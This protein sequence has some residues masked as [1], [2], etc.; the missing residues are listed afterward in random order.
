MCLMRITDFRCD[1]AGGAEFVLHG[2][3]TSFA[4]ALRV[5]MSSNVP[6]PAVERV[7]IEENTS[8]FAD[9]FI[10]HRVGLIPIR[11]PAAGE[12]AV[13]AIGPGRVYASQISSDAYT[14]MRGDVIL[15]SLNSGETLRMKMHVKTDTGARHARHN[16][17]VAARFAPRHNGVLH[18]ECLCPHTERGDVCKECGLRACTEEQASREMVHFFQFETTG[19]YEPR[20]LLG[21]ALGSIRA[22]LKKISNDIESAPAKSASR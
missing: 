7:V 22:T 19:T 20:R 11:G 1:D 8:A 16:P 9:E 4:N 12:L 3:T 18:A 6:T 15:A 14:V 17:A 10:A 2:A 21:L 13:N 5:A